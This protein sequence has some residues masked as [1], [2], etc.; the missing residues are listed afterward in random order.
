M[1]LSTFCFFCWL[2]PAH[3]ADAMRIFLIDV[4]SYLGKALKAVFTAN[5]HEVVSPASVR[6]LPA[7]KPRLT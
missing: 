7:Q 3:C 5:Q 6:L 4:S 1:Y 2:S